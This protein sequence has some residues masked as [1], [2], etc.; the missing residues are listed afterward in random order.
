MSFGKHSWRLLSPFVVLMWVI[1]VV[2]FSGAAR[3]TDTSGGSGTTSTSGQ[4]DSSGPDAKLREK[5]FESGAQ[6]VSTDHFDAGQPPENR[7]AFPDG[8]MARPNPLTG[9][10]VKTVEP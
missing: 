5:A 2:A 6:W 3:A 7:V 8:K 4:S 1:A 9:G 10:Q